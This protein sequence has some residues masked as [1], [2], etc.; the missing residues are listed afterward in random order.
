MKKI[1]ECPNCKRKM[2]SDLNFRRKH[3]CR[4]CILEKEYKWEALKK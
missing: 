2:P 3:G 1:K 4:W